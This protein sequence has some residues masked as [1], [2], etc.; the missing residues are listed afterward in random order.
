MGV[1]PGGGT[2]RLL[3]P[4]LWAFPLSPAGPK[5]Q[6]GWDFTRGSGPAAPSQGR[7]GSPC[8]RPQGKL[9]ASSSEDPALLLCSLHTRTVTCTQ[10][11]MHTGSHPGTHTCTPALTRTHMH[12]HTQTGSHTDA[13]TRTHRLAHTHNPTHAH[14]HRCRHSH[15]H[16]CTQAHTLMHTHVHTARTHTC[17][18]AHTQT[19][20]HTHTHP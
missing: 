4:L 17:T 3:P 14:T 19:H 9:G 7:R 12:T 10:S 13:Q 18:P 1:R 11:H 5:G 6:A 8:R 15:I 16:P 2:P 20:M